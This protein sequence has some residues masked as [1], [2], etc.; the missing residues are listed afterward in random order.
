[1]GRIGQGQ[2][3]QIFEGRRGRGEIGRGGRGRVLNKGMLRKD[4]LLLEVCDGG[5]GWQGGSRLEGGGRGR[6]GG[7]ELKEVEVRRR[8]RR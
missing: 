4:Q 5:G 2:E 8:R 7:G 6:G 3:R 1:M